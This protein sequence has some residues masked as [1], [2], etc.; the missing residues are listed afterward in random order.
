[1]IRNRETALAWL[2]RSLT[3]SDTIAGKDPLPEGKVTLRYG[4][5][6]DSNGF[7]RGGTAR[8]FVNDKLVAEGRIESTVPVGFTAAELLDV[9]LNTS[10]PSADIYSG[11]FPLPW[12]DPKGQKSTEMTDQATGPVRQTMKVSTLFA[13]Q[14]ST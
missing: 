14:E 4:V 8:L 7:G 6:H 10:T 13:S 3:P 9:G 1:L 5:V 2:T 12:Q 11:A